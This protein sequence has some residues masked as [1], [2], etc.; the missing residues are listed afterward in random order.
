MAGHFFGNGHNFYY[1]KLCIE[2]AAA[3]AEGSSRTS[4][5]NA[6]EK[7]EISAEYGR[8]SA[9]RLRSHLADTST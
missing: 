7:I 3:E 8:N 9:D 2:I 4:G 5:A 1:S 6:D